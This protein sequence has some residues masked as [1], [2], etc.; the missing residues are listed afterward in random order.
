M[1]GVDQSEN[2]EIRVFLYQILKKQREFQAKVVP[3]LVVARPATTRVRKS[4]PKVLALTSAVEAAPVIEITTPVL[5]V[6]ESI[7]EDIPAINLEDSGVFALPENT[8]DLESIF[9]KHVVIKEMDTV[10]KTVGVPVPLDLHKKMLD[11]LACNKDTPS[12]PK[13]LRELTLMC[14]SYTM[15]NLNNK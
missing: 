8:L 11:F 9:K 5:E 4:P 14:I 2:K 10:T 12:S 13:S 3:E 1:V 6:V 7:V 15:E